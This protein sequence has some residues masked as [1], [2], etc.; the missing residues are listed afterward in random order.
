MCEERRGQVAP[1]SIQSACSAVIACFRLPISRGP[2]YHYERATGWF[3]RYEKNYYRFQTRTRRTRRKNSRKTNRTKVSTCSTHLLQ[4]QS[5]AVKEAAAQRVFFAWSSSCNLFNKTYYRG[6]QERS[7][8]VVEGEPT[9]YNPQSKKRKKAL[10]V[11]TQN[12]DNTARAKNIEC[13]LFFRLF[14]GATCAASI[15]T[16]N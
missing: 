15:A 3:K 12:S 10:C 7:R 13:D 5:C 8:G 6:L 14:L 11:Y 16:L 4:A 9:R 1:G 2:E